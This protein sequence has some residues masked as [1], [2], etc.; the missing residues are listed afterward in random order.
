MKVL[1]VATVQSHIA[2]FHTGAISLLKENG[3]EIHVAARNN[4]AEKNG[5]KLENVD[6]IFNIPFN[7]S[8]FSY[9]NIKAYR[10]LKK[11][12]NNEDYSIIHCNTPV[13]GILTRLAARKTRKKG[14][15]IIYT[16]HGFHF[17]KGAP[18]LNWFIY[19]PVEKILAHLTDKLV[20]ITQEDYE[21]ASRKF[22]CE[23]YRVHGVGVK[24]KKYSAVTYEQAQEFRNKIGL[25]N[26]F[27]ILCIG[28][29]NAN[30]NQY[31]II[32][33]IPEILKKI[34]NVK[35]LIAGNGPY[36]EKL[37]QLISN[38]KLEKNVELL[39]Y[40]TDLEWYVHACD[41]VVTASFREGLPVNVLEAMFCKKA[42]V[43]SDN[44]GHRELIYDGK[45]G[46]LVLP[47]NEQAFAEK[48][49]ELILDKDKNKQ[50]GLCGKE[51]VRKYTDVNVRKELSTLY[52]TRI[53]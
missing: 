4:L 38:L 44:R 17:Y 12:I 3:Y 24:T 53:I 45:N 19:Y 32:K 40:R 14:T 42:V 5:L 33:A 21:L 13:G 48:I 51:M 8:P 18:K 34:S 27:V 25:K 11:I 7:R 49:E 15:T 50:M 6:Q 47:S 36:E 35:L 9:K 46:Y 10:S 20:T 41:L 31:T 28:E 29:L 2:Q 1:F 37:K 23:V 43:A 30:K 16:A 22:C 39:G 52:D 26:N